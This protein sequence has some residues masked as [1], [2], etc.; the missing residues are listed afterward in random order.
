V[1]DVEYGLKK[2]LF[3]SGSLGLGQ[4]GK[5]LGNAMVRGINAIIAEPKKE[6]QP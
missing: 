3:I 4:I 5:D 2:I 6:V 1:A